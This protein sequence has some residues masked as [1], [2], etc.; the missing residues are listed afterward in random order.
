MR[1]QTT[2]VLAILFALLAGFYYVYEIRL[3]PEREEAAARGFA[4]D[5]GVLEAEGEGG[6]AEGDHGARGVEA[7][8]GP[9]ARAAAEEEDLVDGVVLGE[10][11]VGNLRPEV[12]PLQR[13]E[14]LLPRG[15]LVRF[16]QLLGARDVAVGEAGGGC[17]NVV[18]VG[19]LGPL[20]RH[21]LLQ[22]GQLPVENQHA[23][24]QQHDD[25]Q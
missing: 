22:S 13:A 20:P 23:G 8:E 16:K 3:G 14:V 24:R 6:L 18:A 4:D 17:E 2:A 21:L 1:W 9:A 19:L 10:G 25:G 7:E 15:W 11:V 5:E 12:V